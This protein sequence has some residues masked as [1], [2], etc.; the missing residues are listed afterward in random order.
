[1]P[2]GEPSTW[3]RAQNVHSWYHNPDYY[4]PEPYAEYPAHL[5][6]D[7]L[8]RAQGKGFGRRMLEQVMD[9]LRQQGIPGAHLGVSLMNTPAFGF[10][11][12]L[13]FRELVRVGEGRDGCSYM[14]RRL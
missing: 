7:L 4:C 12:R 13:G 10:Y 2:A 8:E 3:T 1:M 5:H 9:R 11:E 6:I 14:G